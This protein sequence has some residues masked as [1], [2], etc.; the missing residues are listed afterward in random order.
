MPV[1]EEL[2]PRLVGSTGEIWLADPGRP[3]AE[4]FFVRA[5]ARWSMRTTYDAAPPHVSI[6]RLRP[7]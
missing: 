5:A 2:L 6:R 4:E 7:R 3:A 1:L